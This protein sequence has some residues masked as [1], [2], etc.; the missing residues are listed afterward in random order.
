MN[1]HPNHVRRAS[2]A[3]G[4]RMTGRHRSFRRA[5]GAAWIACGALALLAGC[6]TNPISGRQQFSLVGKGQLLA[7][8]REAVPAQFSSDYGVASDRQANA[9]VAQVGQR[10]VATLKPEDVVFPD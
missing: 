3:R 7:L 6:V 2:R 5:R 1:V 10:L 8:A 9:Y 4:S